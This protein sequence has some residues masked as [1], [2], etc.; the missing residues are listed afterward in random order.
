[1][2]APAGLSHCT[3]YKQGANYDGLASITL[4]LAV[5]CTVLLFYASSAPDVDG[6]LT[7]YS[8][9]MYFMMHV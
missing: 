1:M 5:C 8:T 3:V 4:W 2:S 6:P 9:Y 7:Q